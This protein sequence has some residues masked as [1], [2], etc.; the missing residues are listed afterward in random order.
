MGKI[1]LSTVQTR[2]NSYWDDQLKADLSE[3]KWDR[4]GW[5]WQEQKLSKRLLVFGKLMIHFK[6]EQSLRS[7]DG[8]TRDAV[9]PAWDWGPPRQRDRVSWTSLLAD[10][11]QKSFTSPQD[12]LPDISGLSKQIHQTSISGGLGPAE[13]LAGIWYCSGSRWPLDYSTFHE[14]HLSWQHQ[15]FW[16]VITPCRSFY[17]MV[18]QCKLSEAQTYRAPSWSW[19]SCSGGAR[20]LDYE[21]EFDNHGRPS[22]FDEAKVEDYHM[23][24]TGPD[25]NGRVGPGSYLKLSGFMHRDP[26][27][28]SVL[29]Y[30]G[31]IQ[32]F[33]WHKR[34]TAQ[35]SSLDL[36]LD[37]KHSPTD[38]E[39]NLYEC[40][41]RVFGLWRFRNI[42][43][44]ERTNRDEDGDE[45][46]DS[47]YFYGLLLFRDK[48]SGSHFRVG[49]FRGKTY[50][51]WPSLSCMKSRV[52]DFMR[53][54]GIGNLCMSYESWT[55][56]NGP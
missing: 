27:D 40:E 45:D 12:R 4:R 6:C 29:E 38:Q 46:Y 51:K 37:W 22:V 1:T 9:G 5:V 31:S 16:G 41:I 15:L 34:K 47:N 11:T 24:L 55:A 17:Q 25:P 36:S 35:F 42:H 53:K 54:D 3:C 8:S 2:R 43:E 56:R 30:V 48:V 10:Y 7:E 21:P 19:A 39:N 23:N 13:Y 28:L 18:E 52:N 26:P 14:Y 50:R 49:T 20:W 44:D 32:F 33:Q